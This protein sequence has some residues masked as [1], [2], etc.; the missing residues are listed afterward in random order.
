MLKRSIAPTLAI[1]LAACGSGAS[2]QAQGTAP[3]DSGIVTDA[4]AVRQVSVRTT[5]GADGFSPPV[6]FSVPKNTRSITIVA[7]GTKGAL[8]A[9]GSLTMG[10][11]ELVNASSNGF[12]AA[13]KTAYF[14][15]QS[16]QPPGDLLQTARLGTFTLVYPYAPGQAPLDGPGELRVASDKDSGE[17]E[18]TIVMPAEDGA[19]ALHVNVFAVSETATMASP[20]DFMGQAQTIFDQVGLR[21]V[22]DSVATIR[23]SDLST[24][25]DFTEPQEGPESSSAKLAL[26]GS[27][28]VSSRALNVFVVDRL[29]AGIA[30]LSLGVPGPPVPS[31]YYFGV[32]M[33]KASPTSLATTFA[34]EAS[35]F[36][37]LQ[38]VVNKGVSGKTYPD[39]LAD[40]AP[41][42][43]NLM[44]RGTKLTP[45]Q[46]YALSRSALLRTE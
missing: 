35:H 24:I 14:D 36:L 43:G 1:V 40:T 19:K 8:Y 16:G 20:P 3:A 5:I 17:V 23:D 10:G 45:D 38:H 28:R 11:R 22:V 39:P 9:L 18:V 21:L 30:G 41:G 7:T 2:P 44:E 46:G 15:E 34:H 31:S 37:A 6:R 29:P 25:G 32:V 33:Q 13:M 26:L 27:T 4:D 12:G 42:E